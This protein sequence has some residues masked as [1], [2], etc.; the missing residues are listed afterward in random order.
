MRFLNPKTDFA[1][2]KIFGSEESTD[3]LLD[4][5]NSILGLTGERRLVSITIIDPYQA[6]EILGLKYTYLD[7][8]AKDERGRQYLIEMQ[9]LNVEGFEKRVLYNACKA[10]VGQIGSGQHYRELLAVIAITITDFPMFPELADVVN[11]FELSAQDDPRVTYGG[12]E[13]VFA[14]LPKFLKTEDE[15][16]D[17]A[18]RWLYFLKNAGDLTAIPKRFAHDEPVEH[19][20][21]IA[22][23]A[24][25]TQEELE[26]QEKREI[27]LADQ[28]N[29]LSLAQ[30]QGWSQGWEKGRT[31][32]MKEGMK[33]QKI[34]IARALLDV[35]DDAT[36]A[37]KTGLTPAEIIK[38]RESPEC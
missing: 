17:S 14:E 28:R 3:I 30:K 15:L 29:A 4:F 9:V 20:F 37:A 11:R 1:F 5:L 25:L 21:R 22:N 16:A 19:A 13:L 27:F 7:V 35:L 12:I 36:I 23:K 33:Q 10:Y 26:A 34:D 32:G 38:L 31:A 24:G 8:K 18:D 2:R 6:P